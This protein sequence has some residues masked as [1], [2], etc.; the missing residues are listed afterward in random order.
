MDVIKEIA[1]DIDPMIQMTVDNPS[2]YEDE[3]VPMLDVKV[4]VNKEDK[5]KVYYTFY[6]KP[7]KS[8]FVMSKKSAMPI[9]KKIEYLGKEVFR[10]LHNTKLE[11]DQED[12]TEELNKFMRTE[13][14]R[15]YRV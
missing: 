14:V 4:W 13:S 8:A 9:R 10:R 2:N 12:K 3:K 11:V 7:T 5:N 15:L 1:N 6:E